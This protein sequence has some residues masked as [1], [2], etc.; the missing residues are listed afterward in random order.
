M[1]ESSYRDQEWLENFLAQIWYEHFL[2]IEQTNQVKIRYGRRAKRRLGSISLDPNDRATSIITINRIFTDLE[3]P[4]FVI[5]ATIVHELTHY[6]HGFN[7]PLDQKHKYPHSGG[8]IRQEFAER[9]LEELYIRQKRWLRA[10]WARIIDKNFPL[11]P[12]Y[13][14]K[15]TTKIALPWWLKNI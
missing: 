15:K 12:Q 2:D 7:S 6:A 10:N 4:E 9:N 11:S 1:T 3:I 13:G 8:V 5:K 14:V